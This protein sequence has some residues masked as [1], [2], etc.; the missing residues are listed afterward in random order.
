[1]REREGR[2]GKALKNSLL[3]SQPNQLFSSFPFPFSPRWWG[4]AGSSGQASGSG[5]RCSPWGEVSGGGREE[6]LQT[7]PGT[8]HSYTQARESRERGGG[9]EEEG[10]AGGKE[11]AE[12]EGGEGGEVGKEE[13]ELRE[14]VCQGWNK[15]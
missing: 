1:M 5:C 3:H 14:E 11:E 6:L 4:R 15:V 13:E 7:G 8:W 12:G 9:R 10:T 2:G